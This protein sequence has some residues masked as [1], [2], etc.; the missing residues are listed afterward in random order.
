M[1][2]KSIVFLCAALLLAGAL[3]QDAIGTSQPSVEIRLSLVESRLG[4]LESD[5]SRLTDVPTQ[6][7]R[8]ESK[9]EALTEKADGQ[10]NVLQSAGLMVFSAL[11]GGAI[12]WLFRKK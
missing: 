1:K 6:L 3:A 12:G 7:A 5:V 4:R 11:V 8:I 10:G 2:R 9:L